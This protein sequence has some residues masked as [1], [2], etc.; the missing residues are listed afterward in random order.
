M[1]FPR[2]R[3]LWISEP[4]LGSEQRWAEA[5]QW[6]AVG[7]CIAAV[8]VV[9]LQIVS[10]WLAYASSAA[11]A[12]A[13]F[14]LG[15]HLDLRPVLAGPRGTLPNEVRTADEGKR[16][17]LGQVLFVLALSFLPA[18]AAGVALLKHDPR[19]CATWFGLP[20][21]VVVL[22][23]MYASGIG[24]YLLFAATAFR[25]FLHAVSHDEWPP[26]D[27]RG[28][29]DL[30]VLRGRA[31]TLMRI[32]APLACIIA[33]AGAVYLLWHAEWLRTMVDAAGSLRCPR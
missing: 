29:R 15:L 12:G 25:T 31:L 19:T 20:V 26:P 22:V 28:F 8:V 18:L 11:M 14:W 16:K 33:L 9:K 30:P 1:S 6:G 7:A 23:T 32:G 10:L 17:R 24:M 27:Y 4:D 21:G 2:W 3:Q 5:F 13:M